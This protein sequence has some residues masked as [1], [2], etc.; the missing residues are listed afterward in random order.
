M[1]RP[2]PE[3]WRRIQEVFDAV[4]DLE[5]AARTLYLAAACINDPPL[6][7]EV[8]RL[9]AADLAAGSSEFMDDIVR[10]AGLDVAAQD[11]TRTGHRVGPYRIVREHLQVLVSA[12]R[13]HGGAV[14][15]TIGDAIMATF[16]TPLDGVRAAIEMQRGIASLGAKLGL[17]IGV[18]AGPALV[19]NA[20]GR[21]D[22][23]GHTV[24][25]AA[26][27]QAH[28]AAGEICV[29]RDVHDAAGVI[30]HLAGH[31]EHATS[32]TVAIRGVAAP[33]SVHHL[34]AR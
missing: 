15:K 2:S 24:N 5:P 18:H 26:R 13:A 25:V 10:D 30:E 19:V 23:F 9:L 1:T 3:R 7:E 4:V 20:E 14:V 17:K 12:T 16:S 31:A 21:L 6:R 22:Y 8:E 29:T 32:E 11:I 28:A 34:L 33:V 27:V